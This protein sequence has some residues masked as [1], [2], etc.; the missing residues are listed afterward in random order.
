MLETVDAEIQ[1]AQEDA[2]P[3]MVAELQQLRAR[4]AALK[5]SGG[6]PSATAED[7]DRQLLLA[8]ARVRPDIHLRREQLRNPFAADYRAETS[9]GSIWVETKWRSAENSP[10][11]GR[12]L[13][14]LLGGL[15]SEDRLLVVVN[16][17]SFGEASALVNGQLGDRGRVVG[18]RNVADD[19]ELRAA[20]DGLL[21][22][23]S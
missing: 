1:D 23:T 19:D 2:T 12:T 4:F 9:S 20:L 22:R 18:W 3:E 21:P 17:S 7:Y 8:I 11:R 10:F 5:A 14:S 15:T 6:A 13:P 16:A